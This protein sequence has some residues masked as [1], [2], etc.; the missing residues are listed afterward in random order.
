MISPLS[1]RSVRWVI[2]FAMNASVA[3]V[4]RHHRGQPRRQSRLFCARSLTVRCGRAGKAGVA[5]PVAYSAKL[6]PIKP[7]GTR[8]LAERSGGSCGALAAGAKEGVAR[9]GAH[10]WMRDEGA[11]GPLTR[12]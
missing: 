11:P 10:R 1:L 2:T 6:R 3:P 5:E 8:D 4:L 12:A 7:P 9:R